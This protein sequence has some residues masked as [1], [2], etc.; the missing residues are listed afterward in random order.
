MGYSD[1]PIEPPSEE[2]YPIEGVVHASEAYIWIQ[3]TTQ[4]KRATRTTMDCEAQGGEESDW[5]KQ[6]IQAPLLA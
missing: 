4:L 5:H 2:I 6:S 1:L 3:R